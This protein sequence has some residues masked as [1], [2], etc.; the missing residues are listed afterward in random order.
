MPPP[1]QTFETFHQL[2]DAVYGVLE[3]ASVGPT[4][5]RVKATAISNIGR[6]DEKILRPVGDFAITRMQWG[7]TEHGIGHYVFVAISSQKSCLHMTITFC[8]PIVGYERG[9][10]LLR[11]I[12]SRL[13]DACEM[14]DEYFLD[15]LDAEQE[16]DLDLDGSK[17][18]AVGPARGC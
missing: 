15:E 9:Q 10:K 14:E 11:G 17:S 4:Q 5:G 7:V 16:Q 12:L 8:E 18:T 13:E 6:L 1:R 3:K 2:N